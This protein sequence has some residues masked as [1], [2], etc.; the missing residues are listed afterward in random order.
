MWVGG[1]EVQSFLSKSAGERGLRS[2]TAC[3][4]TRRTRG[5]LMCGRASEWVS[6]TCWFLLVLSLASV[7][8]NCPA[9]NALPST[10]HPP[11]PTIHPPPT[12][13]Y[14]PHPHPHTF[15]GPP[16]LQRGRG[17]AVGPEPWV[18]GG[19]GGVLRQ[20]SAGGGK[21]RRQVGSCCGVAG[22]IGGAG[23]LPIQCPRGCKSAA[24]VGCRLHN[25]VQRVCVCVGGGLFP[26]PTLTEGNSLESGAWQGTLQGS[27]VAADW[28]WWSWAAAGSSLSRLGN[29]CV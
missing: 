24:R 14:S 12:H 21:A 3:S 22:R 25:A 6:G 9:G 27:R 19:G 10:T 5:G 2:L 8:A 16:P 17:L 23:V 7:H 11:P 20:P 13:T 29:S 28:G 1:W 26:N 4:S 18:P 15:C